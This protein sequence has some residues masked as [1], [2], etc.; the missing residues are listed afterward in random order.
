MR[1]QHKVSV[2]CPG[3]SNTLGQKI[4]GWTRN[5]RVTKIPVICAS[6][7]CGPLLF[8]LKYKSLPYRVVLKGGKAVTKAPMTFLPRRAMI[9]KRDDIGGVDS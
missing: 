2:P 8:D 1:S 9:A 7:E 3:L 4:M 6:G 5:H